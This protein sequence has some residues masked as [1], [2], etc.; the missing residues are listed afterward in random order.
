MVVGLLVHLDQTVKVQSQVLKGIPVVL[1]QTEIQD[2]LVRWETQVKTLQ[3]LEMMGTMGSQGVL[4]RRGSRVFQGQMECQV[5][6]EI[7]ELKGLEE[8]QV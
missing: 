7:Q 8:L 4:G 5:S 1:D 6:L 3:Y 2:V